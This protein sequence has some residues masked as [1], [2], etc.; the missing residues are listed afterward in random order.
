VMTILEFLLTG[1]RISDWMNIFVII[2]RF[3]KSL[4]TN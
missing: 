2:T 1:F 4:Q 3:H